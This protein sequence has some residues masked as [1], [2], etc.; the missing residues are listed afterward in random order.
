MENS[1]EFNGIQWNSMEFNGVS[2]NFPW[3]SIGFLWNSIEFYESE[4]DGT[5]KIPWNSMEFRQLTE[6]DGIRF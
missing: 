2:L 4:V 6:F 3:N 1:M 5:W